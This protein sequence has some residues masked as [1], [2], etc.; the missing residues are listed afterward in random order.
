MSTDVGRRAQVAVVGAAV[1]RCV[2]VGG[3]A[4][5]VK[6][7]CSPV[8][9]AA[10]GG[11]VGGCAVGGCVVVYALLVMCPRPWKSRATQD[12]E[13]SWYAWSHVVNLT[14]LVC[15]VGLFAIR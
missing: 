9:G 13:S 10:V 4:K 3:T 14:C 15:F 1:V 11:V 7:F 2:V 8:G 5:V 6:G 12:G